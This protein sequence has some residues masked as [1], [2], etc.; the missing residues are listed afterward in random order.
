MNWEPVWTNISDA[1][2]QVITKI[3]ERYPDIAAGQSRTPMGSMKFTAHLMVMRKVDQEREDLVLQFICGP[4][5]RAS[6]N[7]DRSP[8]FP[9]DAGKDVVA[10]EIE[11]GSGETLAALRPLVLP[12]DEE[13]TEYAAAVAEYVRSIKLFLLDHMSFMLDSLKDPPPPLA[14]KPMR[15]GPPG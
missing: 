2:T 14:G 12:I 10:F 7:P 3:Q 11:R 9:L 8:M 1:Y 4:S 6:W 5:E 13:S 15:K